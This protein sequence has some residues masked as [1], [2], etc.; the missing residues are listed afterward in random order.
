MAFVLVQCSDAF[1]ESQQAFVDFGA[2]HSIHNI[3]LREHEPCVRGERRGGGGKS[4]SIID[5]IR[6]IPRLSVGIASISTTFT[7]CQINKAKLSSNLLSV[8]LGL[9]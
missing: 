8:L 2:F 6:F 4:N 1:F 7:T 3:I 5:G 9:E